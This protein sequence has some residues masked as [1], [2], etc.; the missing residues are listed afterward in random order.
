LLHDL[1]VDGPFIRLRDDEATSHVSILSILSIE[2][3]VKWIFV[4]G[5]R[6]PSTPIGL[7]RESLANTLVGGVVLS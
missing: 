7:R 2:T 4:F 3:W 1:K 6:S 5:V